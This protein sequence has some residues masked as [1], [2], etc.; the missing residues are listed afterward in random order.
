MESSSDEDQESAAAVGARAA[1]ADRPG[2]P[3]ESWDDARRATWALLEQGTE[4]SMEV[5]PAEEPPVSEPEGTAEE[6]LA[7]AEL[8]GACPADPD[9]EAAAEENMACCA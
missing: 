1:A 3:P 7:E 8:P 4:A 6:E 5:E 9:E 2:V